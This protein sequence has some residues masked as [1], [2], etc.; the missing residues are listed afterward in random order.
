MS[1]KHIKLFEEFTDSLS[2]NESFLGSGQIREIDAVKLILDK[3]VPDKF[4][5][6]LDSMIDVLLK[7][8]KFKEIQD[9]DYIRELLDTSIGYVHKD[10]A[11]QVEE[12]I[13][14]SK[15][16]T[17]N[18][19][20]IKQ[21]EDFIYDMAFM[22]YLQYTIEQN[23]DSIIRLLKSGKISKNIIKDAYEMLMF[24]NDQDA[25]NDIINA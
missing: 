9:I 16:D 23:E 10:L 8:N 6:V 7:Y 18:T 24:L 13:K 2:L 25:L 1:N 17:L 11:Y 14:K 19:K 4:I 5:K 3:S 22:S 21:Y 20:E 15:T 12:I